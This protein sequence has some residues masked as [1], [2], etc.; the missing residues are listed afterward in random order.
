MASHVLQAPNYD[1]ALALDDV[2]E[3]IDVLTK[4][5][6]VEEALIAANWVVA[7]PGDKP[8][9]FH[10][11]H[12]MALSASGALGPA[13]A[14][15]HLAALQNPDDGFTLINMALLLLRANRIDDART[16]LARILERCPL[17]RDDALALQARLDEAIA[18]WGAPPA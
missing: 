5:G 16:I 6:K 8:A 3:V 7:E 1:A 10:L 15:L 17:Y 12:G 4:A 13:I 14:S 18:L 11:V 9:Q 2:I